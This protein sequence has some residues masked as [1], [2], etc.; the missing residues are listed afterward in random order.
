MS[1]PN[2]RTVRKDQSMTLDPSKDPNAAFHAK[3]SGSRRGKIKVLVGSKATV[4]RQQITG[5]GTPTYK[6]A[7][8]TP[9]KRAL[10]PKKRQVEGNYIKFYDTGVI[11][12]GGIWTLRQGTDY[13]PDWSDPYNIDV[14]AVSDIHNY[15]LGVDPSLWSTTFKPIT[16]ADTPTTEDPTKYRIEV[17]LGSSVLNGGTGM[18]DI[19]QLREGTPQWTA[20]GLKFTDPI[21]MIDAYS[22]ML[23]SDYVGDTSM[24]YPM[25]LLV[26]AQA[27]DVTAHSFTNKITA[28]PNWQD[29]NIPFVL[30]PEGPEVHMYMIPIVSKFTSVNRYRD[31][32]T[33]GP[34]GSAVLEDLSNASCRS[35]NPCDMGIDVDPYFAEVTSRQADGT[36][37]YD[38]YLANSV[39]YTIVDRNKAFTQQLRGEFGIPGAGWYEEMYQ[40]QD[41]A[42]YHLA[43]YSNYQVRIANPRG[44]LAPS[45][46]VL[47]FYGT[48]Y[49]D[50][51][52]SWDFTQSSTTSHTITPTAV[53]MTD[54]YDTLAMVVENPG[55][56]PMGSTSLVA[57]IVQ[58]TNTYYVWRPYVSSIGG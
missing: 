29:P 47:C 17:A 45:T 55:F 14:E 13:T 6:A 35:S 18:T 31:D 15:I 16:K 21:D 34:M 52:Q 48:R 49:Y 30:D 46:P 23:D 44:P 58:G 12:I 27:R 32:S 43:S 57:V 42:E 7:T 28:T 50:M 9:P 33:L 41:Y 3:I 54:D 39:K 11:N 24:L 4:N 19:R 40:V 10:L 51:S 36:T 56:D 5:T 25:W 26:G 22:F 20:K 53:T 8:P 1:Q 37:D 2:T 38:Q